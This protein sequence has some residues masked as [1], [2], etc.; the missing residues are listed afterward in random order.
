MYDRTQPQ[1]VGPNRVPQRITKGVRARELDI[2]PDGRELVYVAARWGQ[3]ALQTLDI[4][5]GKRVTLL[6]FEEGWQLNQPRYLEQADGGW[7]ILVSAQRDGGWRDLF[8]REPDGRMTRLTANPHRE[9]GPVV[10]ADRQQIYFSSDRTG[11][12]NIHRLDRRT[13][14]GFQVTRV[15]GAAHL[16]TLS[17]DNRSLKMGYH[18]G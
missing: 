4:R 8:V 15:L 1:T 14:N 13:G 3:T 6:A 18:N 5:T 17:P 2:R 12:W 7:R 9:I 16:P 10:S 11:I